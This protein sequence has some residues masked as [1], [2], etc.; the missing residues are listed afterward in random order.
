MTLSGDFLR[1]PQQDSVIS[2]TSAAASGTV[3]GRAA[4]RVFA[5]T[6]WVAIAILPFL[7]IAAFLTFGR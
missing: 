5:V 1:M 2:G 6:R 3:K 7:V 4:D